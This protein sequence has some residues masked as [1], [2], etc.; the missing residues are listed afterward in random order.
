M[1]RVAAFFYIQAF[2]HMTISLFEAGPIVNIAIKI[3]ASNQRGA[4][5][6]AP[7]EHWLAAHQLLCSGACMESDSDHESA[8][9]AALA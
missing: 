9:E 4:P 1:K 2:S 6:S 8:D 3:G 5:V 7:R